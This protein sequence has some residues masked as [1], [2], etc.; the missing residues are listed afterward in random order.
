MRLRRQIRHKHNRII[1]SI[2]VDSILKELPP[3]LIS[4]LKASLMRSLLFPL[5]LFKPFSICL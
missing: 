3:P 4:I 1:V 2:L 5:G